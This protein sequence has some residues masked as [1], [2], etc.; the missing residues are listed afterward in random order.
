[1]SLAN[2]G[3][4]F[5]D[6]ISSTSMAFQAD[7]LRVLEDGE[8]TPLGIGALIGAIIGAKILPLFKPYVLKAPFGFLF[9]YVSLKYIL[10]YFN[11]HI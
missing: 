5:P 10:L 4:L 8:F 3:A 2:K 1:M 11:I 9:Q 7:L 6:E